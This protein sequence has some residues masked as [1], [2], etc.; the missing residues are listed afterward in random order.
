VLQG[1]DKNRLLIGVGEAE[2][3]LLDLRRKLTAE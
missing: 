1:Y 3:L 2:H